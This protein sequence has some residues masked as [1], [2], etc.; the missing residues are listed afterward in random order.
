MFTFSNQFKG[1]NLAQMC[2]AKH[3]ADG[4]TVVYMAAG[5]ANSGKFFNAE[6]GGQ[7]LWEQ[8]VGLPGVITVG[9][10]ALRLEN[11]VDWKMDGDELRVFTVNT[12]EVF[13]GDVVQPVWAA[14][15]GE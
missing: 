6:E 12:V 11:V 3:D 4:R 13:K 15:V 7:A 9:Q 8:I 14:L 10:R 2:S 5:V 1:V